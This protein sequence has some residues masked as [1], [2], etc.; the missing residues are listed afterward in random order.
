MT[1]TEYKSLVRSDLY[2]A[3]G[4]RIGVRAFLRELFCGEAWAYIFWMRTCA[5]THP[6]SK[7]QSPIS[8]LFL[9]PLHLLARLML[10]H[11]MFKYGI[12]IPYGTQIGPGFY[13]GH[14]GNIIVNGHSRIGKNCNLS[15][16]VTIGQANRGRRKGYPVIG[17]NVYIGPGAKVIGAVTVGNN[18]AKGGILKRGA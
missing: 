12:L 13:I 6:N 17:D 8:N 7:T 2:R 15:P 9:F 5:Y 14:F 16:G 4:G 11:C 18:V 3:T 1:F 10:R